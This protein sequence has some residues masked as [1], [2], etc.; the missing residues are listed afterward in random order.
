MSS[1][2]DVAAGLSERACKERDAGA[3]LAL[4]ERSIELRHR[5][6]ALIRYLHAQYL[7]APLEERH[8]EYVKGVAARLS[9]EAL[10]HIATTART[11]FTHDPRP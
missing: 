2:R 4:L 1:S 10:T 6:I 9:V 5:R 11:R 7:G 8:H 3:A